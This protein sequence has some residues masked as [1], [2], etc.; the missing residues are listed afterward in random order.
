MRSIR[1]APL[2]QAIRPIPPILQ[3]RWDLH[4]F[5]W[6]FLDASASLS[7]RES[8]FLPVHRAFLSSMRIGVPEQWSTWAVRPSE[9][10]FPPFQSVG[11]IAQHISS[12]KGC[13]HQ[14]TPLRLR[15]VS[16]LLLLVAMSW[17]RRFQ[18]QF[19]ADN[20]PC[21]HVQS[22][23]QSELYKSLPLPSA[24][25]YRRVREAKLKSAREVSVSG[26][27]TVGLIPQHR[28][29]HHFRANRSLYP[30]MGAYC[31]CSGSAIK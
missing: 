10:C 19:Q 6:W 8:D 28:K 22:R 4:Q 15:S 25:D 20:T 3:S 11:L 2:A 7:R 16:P 31:P 5:L 1:T 13:P 21:R 12:P 26:R 24:M 23:M 27:K 17:W 14:T 29:R 18:V 30:I 9:Y